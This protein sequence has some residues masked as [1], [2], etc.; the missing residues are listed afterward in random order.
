MNE[1]LLGLF[2]DIGWDYLGFC[3]GFYK[4]NGLG[5]SN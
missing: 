5:S 3:L 1:G 2:S 4:L